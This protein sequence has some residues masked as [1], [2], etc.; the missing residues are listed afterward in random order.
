MF[1]LRNATVR[2]LAEQ[3]GYSRMTIYK[4][5]TERVCKVHKPLYE[6]VQEK[7]AKNKAEAHMRGGL[8]TSEMWIWKKERIKRRKE[9]GQ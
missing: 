2:S 9:K 1:L 8:K 4:D 7:L 3:T 6:K 5:I